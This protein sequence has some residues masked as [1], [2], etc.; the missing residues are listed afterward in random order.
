MYWVL[1]LLYKYQHHQPLFRLSTAH[2]ALTT[3]LTYQT[4]LL[5]T[6]THP[7]VSPLSTPPSPEVID[8]LLPLLS[9]LLL[10]LPN[11]LPQPIASLHALHASTTDLLST[12]SYLSDTLHMSRQTTTLAARRLK[13]AKE[14]VERMKC[15]TEER[16]EGIRWVEKG[17]WEKRL[18]GR[19]CARV[20][21]EVVGGFE[22]VCRGW[23]ERLAGDGGGMEVVAG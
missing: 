23:R 15:E 4:R 3:H 19:E 7:L 6:L 11:P 18:S 5:Q 8:P 21:G 13:A 16:E 22:E 1:L 9:S 14:I 12:L 2:T 20:C 17:G 10:S